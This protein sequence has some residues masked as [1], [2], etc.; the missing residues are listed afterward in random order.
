MERGQKLDSNSKEEWV[1]APDHP[2]RSCGGCRACCTLMSIP[3]FESAAGV[4][5]PKE[6][7]IGCSI[8]EIK[9]K[10]CK[11]YECAWLGSGLGEE[12]RPDNIRVM[13]SMYKTPLGNCIVAQE[14]D[15]DSFWKDEVKSFVAVVAQREDA[16]VLI[17]SGRKRQIL[18]PEWKTL[19]KERYERNPNIVDC[20]N[21]I[22]N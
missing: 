22:G 7:A 5:C 2:S 14:L 16:F 9:P 12:Y 13:I 11:E 4:P 20:L 1:V 15:K 19:L 18:F 21:M 6:C 10:S 8:H 17:F 3:E